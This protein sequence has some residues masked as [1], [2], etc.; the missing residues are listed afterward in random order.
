MQGGVAL[1]GP[2]SSLP[3]GAVWGPG[4]PSGGWKVRGGAEG[5]QRRAPKCLLGGQ[6]WAGAGISRCKRWKAWVAPE[7]RVGLSSPVD[8]QAVPARR[9][10]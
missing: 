8:S 10:T 1:P 4:A 7:G 9:A 3:E 6:L 2:H 5:R